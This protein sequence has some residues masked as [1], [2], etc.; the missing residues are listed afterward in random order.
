MVVQQTNDYLPRINNKQNFATLYF[1]L[2]KNI[3]VRQTIDHSPVIISL[4]WAT[5]FL[6]EIK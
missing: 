6:N 5:I 4:V 2:F 1:I 3:V